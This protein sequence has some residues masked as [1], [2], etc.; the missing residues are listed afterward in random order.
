MFIPDPEFYPSRIQKQQQKRGV[1][2]YFLS[3]LFCSH[4]FHITENYFNFKM[5]KKKIWTNFQ[6]IIELFY[7]KNCHK[8]LKNMGLGSEIRD[9]EK[10]IPEPGAK[11]APDPGSG[12]LLFLTNS[13]LSC[14]LRISQG[15]L[16]LNVAKKTK[17]LAYNRPKRIVLLRVP[18]RLGLLI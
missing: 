18:L 4:K 9:P 3:Y 15:D 17:T 1:K 7:S 12:T 16:K 8:A 13:M 5:L 10:P 11:K 14:H 2:N 6:R